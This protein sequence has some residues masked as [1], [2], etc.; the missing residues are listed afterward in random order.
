MFDVLYDA[1]DPDRL[2]GVGRALVLAEAAT[3]AHIGVDPGNGS[4]E[5]PFRGVGGALDHLDGLAGARVGADAAPYALGPINRGMPYDEDMLFIACKRQK[6]PC[7]T[8][9]A[10][11]CAVIPTI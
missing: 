10:A 8:D 2:V 4:A 1:V 6:R 11:D 5:P 3:D 7:G 9:I